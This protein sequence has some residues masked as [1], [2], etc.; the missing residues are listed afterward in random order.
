M[1]NYLPWTK[2]NLSPA[3][4]SIAAS[5]IQLT[6]FFSMVVIW[7]LALMVVFG[8]PRQTG[9]NPRDP[10]IRRAAFWLLCLVLPVLVFGYYIHGCSDLFPPHSVG[11]QSYLIWTPALGLFAVGVAIGGSY[12]LSRTVLQYSK[13]SDVFAF[14]SRL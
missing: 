14:S 10:A 3:E 2:G 11:R 9:A 13:L 8:I 1:F 7:L 4:A 6:I 12:L 5:D